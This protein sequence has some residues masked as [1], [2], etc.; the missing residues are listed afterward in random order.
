M[1]AWLSGGFSTEEG[2]NERCLGARAGDA[3]SHDNVFHSVLGLMD[4]QTS[5]YRTDRDLFANCRQ[6]VT[7]T[8]AHAAR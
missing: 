8:F 2:V 7:Q 1:I 4:V 6:P 3:L 5:A